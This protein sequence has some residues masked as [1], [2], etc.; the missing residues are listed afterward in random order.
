VESLDALVDEYG[1]LPDTVAA[2]TGG[3]GFHYLFRYPHGHKIKNRAGVRPGIDVRGGYVDEDGKLVGTG[4]IVVFP[5]V[6]T[7]GNRYSWITAPWGRDPADPPEW[8]VKLIETPAAPRTFDA[9]SGRVPVGQRH[10]Y[11]LHHAARLRGLGYEPQ[12]I[13]PMIAGLFETRCEVDPP[14]EA[15]EIHD[16]AWWFEDKADDMATYSAFGTRL[17]D[18][19]GKADDPDTSW[20]YTG[21]SIELGKTKYKAVALPWR[22]SASVV[23]YPEKSWWWGDRIPH[24]ASLLKHGD[25]KAGKTDTTFALLDAAFREEAFLGEYATGFT[26]RILYLEEEGAPDVHL[27]LRTLGWT[28]EQCRSLSI[29]EVFGLDWMTLMASVIDEAVRDHRNLVVVDTLSM[30]LQLGATEQANLFSF[31]GNLKPLFSYAKRAG[32]SLWMLHHDN[33]GGKAYR[34]NEVT[35]QFDILLHHKFDE[36]TGIDEWVFDGRYFGKRKPEPIRYTWDPVTGSRALVTKSVAVK[37]DPRTRNILDVTEYLRQHPEGVAWQQAS[38]FLGNTPRATVQEYLD[39][40]V[41]RI[42]GH[43]EVG[44]GRANPTKWFPQETAE[45]AAP[46]SSIGSSGGLGQVQSA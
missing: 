45:S 1:P 3:G 32:V 22:D 37:V 12:E 30:Y 4:Q 27:R 36:G 40:A 34:R 46:T 14:L 28:P 44:G 26:P 9:E 11:L 16:I 15:T 24:P 31:A 10:E 41:E 21:E 19:Q 29:D 39:L 25:A 7:S 35:A 38:D 5:S 6:H 8:L 43:K 42:G 20:A 17:R 2:R 23:E 18:L 33:A 13:E